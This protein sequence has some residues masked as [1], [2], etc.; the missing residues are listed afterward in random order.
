MISRRIYFINKIDMNNYN[1]ENKQLYIIIYI[2]II[3]YKI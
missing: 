2:F 3:M 1:H